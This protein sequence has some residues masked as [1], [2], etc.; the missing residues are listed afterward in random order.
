[1]DLLFLNGRPS[2]YYIHLHIQFTDPKVDHILLFFFFLFSYFNVRTRD[3]SSL[4]L[5]LSLFLVFQSRSKDRKKDARAS[6]GYVNNDLL[7]EGQPRYFCI[8]C[9][10]GNRASGDSRLFPYGSQPGLFPC[11][12]F[13][14]NMH[15]SFANRI[16]GRACHTMFFYAHK[17]KSFWK[18][19]ATKEH[20]AYI[21]T[22][23][24]FT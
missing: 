1:M 15:L 19:D 17:R 4:F 23:V 22:R 8:V 21:K 16:R 5:F 9:S 14:S 12:S 7:R 13:H 24:F 18:S 20:E 10:L 3:I 2:Y 11:P 6:G